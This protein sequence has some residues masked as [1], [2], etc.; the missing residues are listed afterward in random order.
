M[1]VEQLGE[2][3]RV[4]GWRGSPNSLA[5][6]MRNRVPYSDARKCKRCRAIAV[7]GQD[8]CRT[9]LGRWSPL[10]PG[11]G[12]GDSRILGKLERAGLLP[13]E[14]IALPVWRSLAGLPTSQR[15]PARLALVQAWDKRQVEPLHWAKAQRQALDLAVQPGKRQ[16]T[17]WFYENR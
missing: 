7:R 4:G 10:S 14:L 12:R 2:V 6:A 5:A 8:H 9:H 3:K 15:A 13:L 16:F 11:A 1:A 17:A